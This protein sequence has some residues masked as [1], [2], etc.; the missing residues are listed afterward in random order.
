MKTLVLPCVAGA[1]AA[2]TLAV[3]AEA[4]R[5]DQDA[6]FDAV[7]AGR[8]QPLPQLE[9]RVLPQIRGDYLGRPEYDPGSNM[10]R[11]KFMRNGSV[12]WIDVDGRTGQILRR[13]GE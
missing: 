13:S 11:M 12:I 6:A 1:L 3:P 10:Y 5:R 2:T 8:S 4:G 7:R 9:R